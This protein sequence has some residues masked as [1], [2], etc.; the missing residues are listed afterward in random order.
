MKTHII[1]LDADDDFVS[2]RDKMGWSKSGRIFLVWPDKGRILTR[3]L[4]IVLL[5]R[6]AQLLGA[7]LAFMTRDKIVIDLARQLH[8]PVFNSLKNAQVSYWRVRNRRYGRMEF[9]R[10]RHSSP[11]RPD[12]LRRYTHY[13]QPHLWPDRK[14]IRWLIFSATLLGLMVLAGVLVPHAVI[15][16]EPE[17]EV[18]HLS[19][20]SAIDPS[21]NQINFSGILPA[22]RTIVI[23][24]GRESLESSSMKE[25]GSTFATGRIL[26]QNLSDQEMEIPSGLLIRSKTN[27]RISFSTTTTGILKPGPGSTISLPVRALE[28]GKASNVPANTLQAVD[29]PIGLLI[30]ADNPLPTQGGTDRQVATP[31]EI[32]RQQLRNELEVKLQQT[33]LN[34]IISGL[35]EGDL[36]L[37][38]TLTPKR[39]LDE[40]FFPDPG[41]ASEFLEL[42]LRMEFEAYIVDHQD[43]KSLANF[44]LDTNLPAG[45]HPH[46]ESLEV[47]IEQV[48][49]SDP[50]VIELSARRTLQPEI[51]ANDIVK[52][53]RGLRPEQALVQLADELKLGRPARISTQPAWWPWIPVLPMRI[54][55]EV[56]PETFNFH[57]STVMSPGLIGE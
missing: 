3:Q 38:D 55:I 32:D 26:I 10:H 16:L 22:R 23:V 51:P 48:D 36:L 15:H 17:L 43:V 27:W 41:I 54:K 12:A 25:Y 5:H 4:D 28:P 29:G 14:G 8:I 30:S 46:P 7:Q 44:A 56:L 21:L 9:L 49:T 45:Y 11:P 18:Q 57:A 33:A 2:T 24:E 19:L 13:D 37:N 20:T 31:S 39:V 50:L 34:E 6:H 40:Y 42:R 52:S 47:N 1:Y 53:I 35:S